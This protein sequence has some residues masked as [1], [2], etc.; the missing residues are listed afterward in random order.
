M[1]L[2]PF[3]PPIG[4]ACQFYLLILPAIPLEFL[5]PIGYSPFGGGYSMKMKL[6]S[7]V[8]CVLSAFWMPLLSASEET[9]EARTAYRRSTL[10][11][12][13]A[14]SQREKD[15]PR[16]ADNQY[17]KNRSSH[18]YFGKDSPFVLE[19]VDA[20]IGDVVGA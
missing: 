3:P 18:F 14:K 9:P 7:L 11:E 2:L 1:A 5:L 15:S 16:R 19:P 4:T 12:L 13:I 6:I 10:E 17:S 8:V 20:S